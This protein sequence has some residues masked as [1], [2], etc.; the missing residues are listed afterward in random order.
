MKRIEISN[1]AAG[2]ARNKFAD[3]ERW[4]YSENTRELS[5]RAVEL[6]IELDGRELL[7]L[8]LQGHVDCRGQGNVGPAIEV[9][10]DNNAGSEIYTHTKINRK[11][12]TTI[13]GKIRIT[14]L[15]YY[16]PGKSFIH[17]CIAN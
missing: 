3:I 13:F 6:G 16:K 17:C 8:L 7:R 5:L 11:N 1:V 12:L 10:Q 4:I 14:R 15:G 2:L 9:F